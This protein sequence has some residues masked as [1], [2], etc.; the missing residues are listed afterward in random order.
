[1]LE[2]ALSDITR[3]QRPYYL[4]TEKPIKGLNNQ[5]WLVFKHRDADSLLR[6]VFNFLGLGEKQSTYKVIRLDLNDAKTYEYIPKKEGNIPNSILLRTRKSSDVEKFL[7]CVN[8]TTEKNLF[9]GSFLEITQ[10]K[11][12]RFNLPNE[13]EQYN[14]FIS[15]YLD[16][17]KLYRRS[18]AYFNS[19]VLKLYEEPLTNII[20]NEGQIRLLMD[21]QGFTNKRDLETLQKLNDE[22]YLNQYIKQTL[23]DFLR[24]LEDKILDST[25]ILAELV[26]LDI[27]QIKLVKMEENKG[28]YH[29]K[30]GILTDHL[31]NNIQHDGS[32][33]FTYSAHSS[34]AESITLLYWNDK[35]D[36]IAITESIAEFD[37]EWTDSVNTFDISQEFLNCV[38]SESRRRQAAN[39]PRIDSFTPAEIPA[40][41]KVTVTITGD[42]LQDIQ[43]ITANDL[44]TN[45]IETAT[46]ETVTA[47]VLKAPVSAIIFY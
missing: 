33:N 2:Q 42:N 9:A 12:R 28:I 7:D 34:N 20:K 25:T 16:R 15:D 36:G 6:N 43:E 35:L 23:Q 40:G 24:N 26:R 30:T 39:E 44:I 22:N 46:Q 45:S 37:A 10:R 38:I 13:L 8:V 19:G 21:W 27:L 18:T 3:R 1:M 31:G 41:E 5:Y 11:R 29:K 14:K 32:D 4:P 47:I 17:T